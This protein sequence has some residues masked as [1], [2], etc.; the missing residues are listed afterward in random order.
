[1][2]IRK[3]D[4]CPVLVS[5]PKFNSECSSNVTHRE[6]CSL[7]PHSRLPIDRET[8]NRLKCSLIY[9][10]TSEFAQTKPHNLS[11]TMPS[12]ASILFGDGYLPFSNSEATQLLDVVDKIKIGMVP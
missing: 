1:M 10:S 2:L 3:Y 6:H 5:F 7:F 9:F 12:P 11:S 8:I 4:A